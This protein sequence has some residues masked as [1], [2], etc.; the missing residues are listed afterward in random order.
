VLAVL[1]LFTGLAFAQQENCSAQGTNSVALRYESLTEQTGDIII[2][3]TSGVKLAAG[4]NVP[5]VNITVYYNT[6]VTSRLLGTALPSG[7]VPSEALLIIDDPT[8]LNYHATPISTGTNPI[9][10]G[11][12]LDLIPCLTPATG[13]Q[14]TVA[15]DQGGYSAAYA[16]GT[17]TWA[18]NVYQ[19]VVSGSSVTFYGVPVLPPSTVGS[20][21]YRI[22]NVR[23][24]ANV[25]GA[26]SG[27]TPVQAYITVSNPAA[28]PIS[29]S[30]PYVGYI[31]PSL[32]AT[33]KSPGSYN[34]CVS[35]KQ[36]AAGTLTFQELF[37]TAFKT[38]VAAQATSNWAGQLGAGTGGIPNYPG[39]TTAL[40]GAIPN[41]ST[42]GAIY[43]SESGFVYSVPAYNNGGYVPGLAD[44]GTR[45]KATF[46]NI[47]SGV[48][49][50]VTASNIGVPAGTASAPGGSGG[51]TPGVGNNA[52]TGLAILVTGET[53]S[54]GNGTIPAVS[55]DY[56]G[57]VA[58][59][60]QVPI[61]N[62][63]GT[64]V[65][66]VVNTN[67]N[68]SESF[69]FN[70]YISYTAATATNTPLPGVSTVTLS[71]APTSTSGGTASATLPVPRFVL[72]P[73]SG[74]AFTINVCRTILLYPYVTNQAGFDTGMTVANTSS[75]PFGTGLQQGTCT[76]NFYGGTTAAPTTP[77]GPKTIGPVV[78]GTVWADTLSD[79]L[80]A[81]T[82][83]GYAF[84]ICNFQFA[85]GFAF[86]SD[87]GA[88]NLAMGYLAL[89]IPD[90]GTG[91][92]D[93]SP[94]ANGTKTGEQDAH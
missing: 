11:S 7:Q 3:C 34:Q 67:S 87:V 24:N 4:V 41:Q 40:P 50:Y 38:R 84:A 1:T 28:L 37:G 39:G 42:P 36:V 61:V 56:T 47:P 8:V 10:F 70:A 44:F 31:A 64:A 49:V 88:R 58:G 17:T 79:P 80:F 69:Q 18:P 16:A 26:A 77:P 33:V 72:T 59:V 68:Y 51:L 30:Q 57:L 21:V 90:M 83:Q 86:I 52:T 81:P 94:F 25:G 74:T 82:F 5:L 9:S 22:T 73:T 92:R 53:V 66:E 76:F 13:C 71:Y 20:R 75:D 27:V 35:Q 85:H 2:N 15:P 55:S 54:D 23:V 46:N 19:G 62:G 78:A 43:N 91:S 6:Q 29:N 65:W 60:Q 93:P 12:T 48:N 89:I 63:T 45:L 14:Q 32:T